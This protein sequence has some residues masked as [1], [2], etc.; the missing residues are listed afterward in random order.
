M[1]ETMSFKI[2]FRI[3]HPTMDIEQISAA[4]ELQ[5]NYKQQ[6]GAGRKTP[7]G[8]TLD[9]IYKK[10]YWS[11]TIASDDEIGLVKTINSFNVFLKKRSTFLKEINSSGGQLEYF[12]GIFTSS[13]YAELFDWPLLK[14][15]AQLKIAL[16]LDFYPS[17]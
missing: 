17:S 16:H 14:Q 9:G 8:K 10:T 2:S 11:Y 12:I 5:P 7:K 6:V 4:L 13:N 1:N 15:C 3:S